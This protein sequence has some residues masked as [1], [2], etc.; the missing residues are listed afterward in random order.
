[1]FMKRLS[2]ADESTKSDYKDITPSKPEKK[3]FPENAASKSNSKEVSSIHADFRNGLAD[4][5]SGKKNLNIIEKVTDYLFDLFDANCMEDFQV[6]EKFEMNAIKKFEDFEAEEF[7]FE[8]SQLHGEFVILFENLIEKYLRSENVTIEDFYEEVRKYSIDIKNPGE[9]K[10]DQAL[11]VIEVISFYT[12]FESWAMMMRQQARHK[13]EYYKF[14]SMQ[15]QE[16]IEH[17]KNV[18][19]SPAPSKGISAMHRFEDELK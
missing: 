19:I 15:L 5:Q 14:F 18:T 7:T 8:Q 2:D 10:C 12:T 13:A 3:C 1:M 6:I 11:E 4:N 16:A 17:V 9:E